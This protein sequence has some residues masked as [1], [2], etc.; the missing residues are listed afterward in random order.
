MTP[1]ATVFSRFAGSLERLRAERQ[2]TINAAFDSLRERNALLASLLIEQ[3]GDAHR[4]ALWMTS[5][6]RTFGGRSPLEVLADGDEDTLWDALNRA[7]A[8]S[9][10]GGV[11]AVWTATG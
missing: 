9:E 1:T 6:Q 3:L 2:R 4:A 10:E 7:A 8:N 5:H 11:A